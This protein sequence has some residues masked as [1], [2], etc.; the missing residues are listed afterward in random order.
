MISLFIKTFEHTVLFH[1]FSKF[2]KTHKI[3][4]FFCGNNQYFY[5]P[6][7]CKP[8]FFLRQFIPEDAAAP[9]HRQGQPDERHIQYRMEVSHHQGQMG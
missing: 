6:R 4:F 7:K 3:L 5:P 8:L 9:E 1:L 2:G